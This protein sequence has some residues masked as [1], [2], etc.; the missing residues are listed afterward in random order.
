[1]DGEPEPP[2]G[3]DALDRAVLG[4][5]FVWLGLLGGVTAITTVA[6]AFTALNDP[7]AKEL[8]W[9]F[10]GLCVLVTLASLVAAVVVPSM[11]PTP[12]RSPESPEPFPGYS[13]FAARFLLRVGL[14]EGAGILS[15]V[16][17][18]VTGSWLQLACVAVSVGAMIAARP[19]R[20]AIEAFIAS[21]RDSG[22]G[23][24]PTSSW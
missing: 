5:W 9:P 1:M 14:V 7:L 4:L 23:N 10:F 24:R 12:E 18:F 19:T 22:T 15:I 8:E 3:P 20:A 6:V 16:G 13:A 11:I 17:L 2:A 21:R